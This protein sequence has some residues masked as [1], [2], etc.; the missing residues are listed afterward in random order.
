MWFRPK[1]PVDAE[2]WEW[3]LAGFQWLEREFPDFA[4]AAMYEPR[5]SRST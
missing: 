3:L 5:W 1:R 2:E 4:G